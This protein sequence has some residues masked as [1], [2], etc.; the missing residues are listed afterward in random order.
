MMKL[1]TDRGTY[2]VNYILPRGNELNISVE[3]AEPLSVIAGSLE[4]MAVIDV[5]ESDNPNVTH[6]YEGYTLLTG[7]QRM[8][9]GRVRVTLVRK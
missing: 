5:T 9:S 6:T 8:S 1:V 4:G 7:I 2:D 3:S